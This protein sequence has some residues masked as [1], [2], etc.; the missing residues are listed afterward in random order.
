MELSGIGIQKYSTHSTRSAVS[1]ESKS[2]RMS[3]KNIF[4]CAEWT[5]EK[6]FAQHCDKEIEGELDIRFH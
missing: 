6:T 3:L 2:M 4:R 1:S 5:S